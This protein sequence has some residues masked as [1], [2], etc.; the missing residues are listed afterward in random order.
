MTADQL[1]EIRAALL[2]SVAGGENCCATFTADGDASKWVQFV[3]TS[4]NC[5][6]PSEA[7]PTVEL[8]PAELRAGVGGVELVTWEVGT[9]VTYEVGVLDVDALARLIDAVFVGLLGCAPGAY[10]VD[11]EFE[12]L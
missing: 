9:F 4:L 12:Q 10:E 3:G 7:P 6:Y 11:V 1:A 5:A 8:L 2:E